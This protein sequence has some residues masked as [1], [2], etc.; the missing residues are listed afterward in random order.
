MVTAFALRLFMFHLINLRAQ[1]VNQ[2]IVAQIS[3]KRNQNDFGDSFFCYY[4]IAMWLFLVLVII[5]HKCNR[6][7]AVQYLFTD[8]LHNLC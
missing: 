4:N 7:F 5:E 6:Y 1:I 8:I 3:D 2:V